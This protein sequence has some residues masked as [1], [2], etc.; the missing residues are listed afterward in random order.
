MAP[1]LQYSFQQTLKIMSASTE[2]L[3]TKCI[4]ICNALLRGE[5]A[6]V[7]SYGKVIA[8]YS[9]LPQASELRRI[10]SDHSKSVALLRENILEMGGTPEEGSGAWGIFAAAVQGTANLLGT[11]SAIESLKKGEENGRT[12]YQE[13]LLSDEVLRECKHLIREDLLPPVMKHIAVLER[14]EHAV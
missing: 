3:H 7:D 8:K 6:A 11:D 2:T 12:D 4:E 14:M 10:R 9:D 1:I 5:L 13:A